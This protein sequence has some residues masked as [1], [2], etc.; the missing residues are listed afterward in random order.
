MSNFFGVKN[1]GV[2]VYLYAFRGVFVCAVLFSFNVRYP[3]AFDI[4]P[5]IC[6]V[7]VHTYTKCGEQILLLYY[8]NSL[9]NH[10]MQ[11][12]MNSD[13]LRIRWCACS[14]RCVFVLDR[15]IARERETT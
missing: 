6:C 7:S 1:E 3:N 8:S 2:C 9:S 11:A 5:T 15:E 13:C 4:V 10:Q 12:L 14:C